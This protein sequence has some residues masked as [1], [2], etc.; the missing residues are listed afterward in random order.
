M[1]K[2]TNANEKRNSIII[3]VCV[4]LVAAFIIGIL[5]YNRMVDS[6][7]FLR[8]EVAAESENFEV[9][10]A[11][12][13]YYFY[14]NYQSY[15]G[16]AQYLGIDTSKSLKAQTSVTGSGTW[17]DYFASMTQ[18]YIREILALCEAAKA[19]GIELED[20]DTKS[21]KDSIDALRTT[22]SDNGY[23]LNQYLVAAFGA[24]VNEKDVR[25]CLELTALAAKYSE[26]FNNELSY[27]AEQ[28]EAYYDANKADFDCVDVITLKIPSTYFEEKD[29]DGNPVGSTT[30]ASDAAKAQAEKIVA[31]S[32][33]DEF[34]ASVREYLLTYGSATEENIDAQINA[35]YSRGV[36][37]GNI[38]EAADWAF[39]ASV[40]ET[41]MFGES[42]ASQFGVYYILKTKYRDDSHTRNV[43]HILFTS[44]TYADSAKADEIYAEWEAAGFSEEKFIELSAQYNEDPGSAA[45]GGLYE[46]VAYGD[47]ITEFNDWLYDPAR[48]SGDHDIVE[49][50][51]GWHIMYYVGENEKTVWE[52]AARSALQQNDY[53]N[54][55]NEHSVSV[56]FAD[57]AFEGINA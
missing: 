25:H 21:I 45:T 12:M 44:E 31:A 52:N 50:S 48:K 8:R 57:G 55:I 13:T 53:T 30:S 43:R 23:S 6:G 41:K 37:A 11:M 17:F 39:S 15:S 36:K 24:G 3:T 35:C 28:Y 4:I 38:S 20:A 49:T 9:D 56:K 1:G 32:S 14:T 26:K 2:E 5:V 42:G 18:G 7:F 51:Y 22:A 40:G 34:V 16:Y 47:M 19:D 27:T 10:G 29:A 33:E 46:N 54:F